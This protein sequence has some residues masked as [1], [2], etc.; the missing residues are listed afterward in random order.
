MAYVDLTERCLF[1]FIIFF[2]YI[3][4]QA[5][6]QSTG[7]SNADHSK[8]HLEEL[9]EVNEDLREKELEKIYSTSKA[10]Q[11]LTHDKCMQR[12]KCPANR[13]EEC[14]E[15]CKAGNTEEEI[16]EHHELTRGEHRSSLSKIPK[17]K[18]DPNIKLKTHSNKTI[19]NNR[20]V[21]I[22]RSSSDKENNLS[23]PPNVAIP[24]INT[25]KAK[26]KPSTKKKTSRSHLSANSRRQSKKKQNNN[27]T[28][29]KN[30]IK[31]TQ[32]NINKNKNAIHSH[33]IDTIDTTPSLS[34]EERVKL[35]R[36]RPFQ[37]P[38]IP[39]LKKK[40]KSNLKKRINLSTTN[41]NIIKSKKFF[42][43]SGLDLDNI[44]LGNRQRRSAKT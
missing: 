7:D 9:E 40:S 24:I 34:I 18:Y 17:Q 39:V 26:I 19:S 30:N 38:I 11:F 42:L 25:L 27:K 10:N 37:T 14:S 6:S 36:T 44:V 41:K 12:M 2:I 4:Q 35:R 16:E 33:S 20:T 21:S 8:K 5:Q 15:E 43:G 22:D 3:C 31:S 29:S 23:S 1:V 13:K 28:S 32:G